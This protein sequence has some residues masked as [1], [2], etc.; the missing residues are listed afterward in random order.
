MMIPP[1]VAEEEWERGR[2]KKKK[3]IYLYLRWL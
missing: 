2:G 1:I 3:E